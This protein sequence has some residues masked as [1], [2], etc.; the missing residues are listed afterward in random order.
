MFS[1]VPRTVLPVSTLIFPRLLQLSFS[2]IPTTHIPMKNKY[3]EHKSIPELIEVVEDH[4]SKNPECSLSS[5]RLHRQ[6][7]HVESLEKLESHISKQPEANLAYLELL[8]RIKDD[9]DNAKFWLG[10]LLAG[11]TTFGLLCLYVKYQ[12]VGTIYSST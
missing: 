12:S 2:T 1:L 8:R 5:F 7:W 10:C 4:I 6:K 9:R 11:V 3:F